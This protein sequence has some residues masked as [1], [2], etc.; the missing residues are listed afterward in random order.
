MMEQ[1]KGFIDKAKTVHGDLYDYSKTLYIKSS[2]KVII[3]C[4]IHGPFEQ[5]PWKHLSKQGCISCGGRKQLNTEEFIIKAQEIHGNVYD[6]SKVKYINNQTNIIIICKTHG[7]FEKRPTSHLYQRSGCSTCSGRKK[8]NTE[9]FII[10]AREIHGDVY[11]YSNVEY[12][13]STTNVIII[14]K[15]HGEFEQ[16]PSSHMVGSG[17]SIC[18]HETRGK[19]RL[20]NTEE[21]IIKAREI[22]EDVYDYSKVEYTNSTTNVIII[23]KI[24]G[25]FEQQPSN[26]LINRGCVDCGRERTGKINSSDRDTFITKAKELH[27]ELYDYSNVN[28]VNSNTHVVITCKTHGDF[29]QS[30][31]GHLMKKGCR[32]CGCERTGKHKLSNTEEFIDKATKV[33]GDLYDYSNVEYV[34]SNENVIII[35]KTHGQ[36]NQKPNHHLNG[37]NCP[38]CK[39]KTE[40]KM[41]EALKPLYHSLI[42]QFKQEWCKNITHLPFD[43]CIPEH[44][45]IIELDGRQHFNQVSNWNSP[46]ETFENDLFKEKCANENGYSVIRILQED[47]F[48]DKY[49]WLSKLQTEIENIITDNTI[50]HNIYICEN[51]EYDKFMIE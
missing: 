17:C 33:H 31:G 26:H 27:G 7:P 25:P 1:T 9:E 50:I 45:I 29:R 21:F 22:H 10:K 35:C 5:T 41:Y 15:I 40:Q 11:D 6:Y 28:Y 23:C 36:F 47:V 3:I 32:T 12:T 13:N 14:C 16:V 37:A 43:F 44:K 38:I 42:T 48:G 51:G 46:E 49:D 39:N 30:P 4:K 24:H 18:G 19:S 2:K 34:K 8:L 20:S